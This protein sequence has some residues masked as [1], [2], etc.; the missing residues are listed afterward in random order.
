MDGGAFDQMVAPDSGEQKWP[1]YR[2]A[3]SAW[4]VLHR[5]FTEMLWSDACGFWIIPAA[6]DDDGGI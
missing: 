3:D 5:E 1:G 4:I 6:T 2:A